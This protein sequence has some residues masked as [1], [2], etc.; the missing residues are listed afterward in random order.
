M[1][2]TCFFNALNEDGSENPVLA[3]FVKEGDEVRL[4]WSAQMPMEAADPGQDPRG[5]P[6]LQNLWHVLDITPRGGGRSRIRSSGLR[7]RSRLSSQRNPHLVSFLYANRVGRSAAS[8]SLRRLS[9]S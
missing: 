3:V 8:P 6:D 7:L 9:S 5:G 1:R 2:V 4:F